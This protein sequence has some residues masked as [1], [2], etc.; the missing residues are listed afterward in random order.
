M[1]EMILDPAA[2]ALGD[3]AA[4]DQDDADVGEQMAQVAPDR[5]LVDGE[6]RDGL[7][8]QRE[9]LRRRQAVRAALGNALADLR[10]DAGDA[11]HEELVEVIGRYRQEPHPLQQR[12]AGI[13]RF[14]Q[15]TAVEVQPGQLAIDEALGAC[16]DRTRRSRE[17][18]LF[19][20]NYNELVQIP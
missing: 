9:L 7:V 12:M 16:G 10:L 15:H 1:E 6:L 17:R 18:L 3:I 4:V 13:D 5:L 2:L 8:D 11:D 14:L 20:F 19:L